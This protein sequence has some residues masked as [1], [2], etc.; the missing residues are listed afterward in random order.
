MIIDI[1]FI[2]V[3]FLA[4]F[5]GL[6]KGFILGIF[7]MVTMII[8]LAAALKLSSV[9]ANY[10]RESGGTIG[11]WLPLLSFLLVFVIVV[12]IVKIVA[13][14]IEK[15]VQMAMLGWLNRMGGLL[16]YVLLYGVIFSVFLFYAEKM[17]MVKADTIRQSVTYPYISSLG[18]LVINNLGKI[19]PV[20]KDMFMQLEGFFE[21]IASKPA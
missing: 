14:V 18:S 6:T 19:I 9:L 11:K 8:G 4:V 5:K 2:I 16:L 12:V 21:R 3:M 10:L 13:R 1:L 7:S 20:F 15:A 17:Y